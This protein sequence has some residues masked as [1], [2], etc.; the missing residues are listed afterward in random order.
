[1]VSRYLTNELI[2]RRPLQER[3]KALV[4]RMNS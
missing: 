3:P 1:L 4:K 2:E